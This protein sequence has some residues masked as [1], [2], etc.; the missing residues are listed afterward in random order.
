MRTRFQSILVVVAFLFTAQCVLAQGSA[1]TL[2]VRGDVL[3]P[4]TNAG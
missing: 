1:A 4:V 3:K 2:D